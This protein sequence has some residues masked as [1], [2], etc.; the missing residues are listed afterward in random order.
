MR[1]SRMGNLKWIEEDINKEK[2]WKRYVKNVN[3]L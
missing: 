2:K 3:Y 1:Q